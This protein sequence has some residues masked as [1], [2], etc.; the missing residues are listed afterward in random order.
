MTEML[1]E[2]IKSGTGTAA[3][4]GRPAA[5]KTGT[6]DQFRDA[7]FVGYAPQLSCAV[8]IGNDDNSKMNRVYGGALAAPIWAEFMK[9]ALSKKKKLAF[10]SNE[11]GEI[12]IIMCEEAKMRA[13]GSCPV[14]AKKF[15]TAGDIPRRFCTKHRFVKPFNK[16]TVKSPSPAK[17]SEPRADLPSPEQNIP[18]AGPS[19]PRQSRKTPQEGKSQS[20]KPPMDIPNTVA[21]TLEPGFDIPHSHSTPMEIEKTPTPMETE[22]DMDDIVPPSIFEETTEPQ[23]TPGN[24]QL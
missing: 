6:T 17:Q 22:E 13:T 21:P 2:V 12:G 10:S 15:F 20:K 9:K 5:G 3:Q 8:W 1:E 7:W 18:S 24:Q 14:T 4:I 23:N 19:T 11:K 16:P